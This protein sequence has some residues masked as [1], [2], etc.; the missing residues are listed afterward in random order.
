MS[1]YSMMVDENFSGE[2][3]V[4]EEAWEAEQEGRR[5]LREE[6]LREELEKQ[7]LSKNALRSFEEIGQ[8][9][10]VSDDVNKAFQLYASAYL[11]CVDDNMQHFVDRDMDMQ[12]LTDRDIPWMNANERDMIDAYVGSAKD[13]L[14]IAYG[15][16]DS[17][18]CVEMYPTLKDFDRVSSKELNEKRKALQSLIEDKGLMGDTETEAEVELE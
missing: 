3:V 13:I 18:D 9:A 14:T 6:M 10:N 16:A 4:G 5:I 2:P 8:L 11:N 7:G 12:P 17:K 15:S 1:K